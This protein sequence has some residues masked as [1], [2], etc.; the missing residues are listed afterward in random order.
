[1]KKIF[2]GIGIAALVGLTACEDKNETIIAPD[3]E[4]GTLS[5]EL[6]EPE[7]KG[8]VY[9]LLEEEDT[10]I[11]ETLTFAKPDY[12]FSSSPTYSVEVS[13]NPEF[14]KQN[15]IVLKMT[16]KTESLELVTKDLNM[17]ILNLHAAG[18][19]PELTEVQDVYFRII[20]VVSEATVGPL[21][22]TPIVKP[23]YSNAITLQVLPYQLK[24]IVLPATY[25]LI[26]LGGNWDNSPAGIGSSLIPLSLV[27]EYPYNPV[28]GKGKFVYTGYFDAKDGFKVIGQPG[29]WADAWGMQD[30]NYVHGS[31]DN[32]S[33][34]VSGY[35]R[36][37][38]DTENKKLAIDPVKIE[39]TP[40]EW[41][42]ILGDFSGWDTAPVKMTAIPVTLGSV[43]TAQITL[44]EESGLKFRADGK[45]DTS[46]GG[47][48]FP[49]GLKPSGD[50]I[51][52]TA[53][54]YTVVFNQ[55]DNCYFF[56]KK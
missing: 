10:K 36:I 26:G 38:L 22:P 20:S 4:N 25:Y 5:F 45:W 13:L 17:A 40:N 43:W 30:G 27:A 55:L 47:K 3:A 49:Y 37:S 28:D 53:G 15:T 9:T 8:E 52:A 44:N 11:V 7:N 39:F 54:N 2:L 19:Y 31:G 50:N 56:F 33:V 41:I 34:P 32:I 29:D 23:A 42:E 51:P 24:E 18:N 6:F 48:T 46:W 14:E 1:M 16:S 12:G 21:D 35:Y